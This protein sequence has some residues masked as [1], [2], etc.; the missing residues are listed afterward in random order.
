MA[1]TKKEKIL[2]VNKENV[3]NEMAPLEQWVLWKAEKLKDKDEYAKVPYQTIG[4]RA[5]STKPHS[6]S[7]FEKTIEYID[8]Y[9][10]IGFVLTKDDDYICLDLD[11]IHIDSETYE[12]ITDIAKEVMEKTWWEVSPSGT[13]VHAYFKGTLPEEV[14][15]KNKSEH[16]ELYS[17]SRFMTFTGVNDGVKRE[18]SSNQ[19]Y[20][21]SLVERYFKREVISNDF[22]DREIT[23]SNL[24]DVEVMQLMARSKDADK[25]SKLM[26]GGWQE[27]FESQ[28]EAD[29]SLL[30]ALAFYTQKNAKQMDRIFRNSDL[31]RNK[32]DKLRGNETYGQ[33]SINK[34]INDCINVYDPNYKTSN[35]GF[36]III[37]EKVSVKDLLIKT[38]K[39][40]RERLIKLW[41]DE[42]K[43][44]RKPTS[45]GTN[46]CAYILDD[47]LTFRLFDLEENTKL[48]MYQEEEGIY[49][50]N[51]TII[52]RVISW[53]EP[54][55]N[56]RKA[57]EVIYH[58][59]NTAKVTRQ[60]EQP[61]LIPVNNGVFNRETGI[62][63]PFTPNYVFTSKIS[64]NYV[65][66][67]KQPNIKG[68]DFDKWLSEIACGDSE[69]ITLLWQVINDAMNG[70]YT[71]KKAIFF[72][73]DGNNG[74]GS[75]QQL[76]SNLIGF[77]NIASLKANEF[78]QEFKLSVLEGKTAV[79]GDDVP[80]GIIIEDSSN[81]KSVV[82]GDSVLVNVKN[83]Q[84]YRAEFR[85]TVIQSSNGMPKFKDKTGGNNRRLLIVPFKADFNGLIENVDIKE[86]YL[87]D[88]QVLEYVLYKAINLDFDKFITP[89]ASL[90]MMELYKQ[91]NDPVYDFKLSVFDEWHIRKI[92]K[93][94]VYGFYKDF[95][96]DNGYYPL[97]ERKFHRQ[98][99]GYLDE[100]W[101]IDAQGKYDWEVLCEQIG[102]LNNM[103]TYLDFPEKNKNYKSYE[104]EKMK[105]I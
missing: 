75:F 35:D 78:E 31:I 8:G 59:T 50:R 47:L 92:P 104:N 36:N 72:I 32:W 44:G 23:P 28:S 53:L 81:F 88:T 16:L 80:V 52:K 102:D 84:P 5:D 76:L 39:E 6:W 105:I 12:P 89:K 33:K 79:I 74:K 29:L 18:I 26:S 86:K 94:I 71:R 55:L 1:I 82:T 101:N 19:P 66:N 96:N 54:R 61:H 20:I 46:R 27:L 43:N 45:I 7:D 14:K 100:S 70:N 99:K 87:K 85:C 42:G 58:L 103:R 98:F 67:A 25:I 40:E 4:I 48:A 95:C 69:I 22:I 97:S 10:G 9:E 73:G 63:E 49:T 11:D 13:G 2:K 21:D 3:P 57:E 17:H 77:N 90:D 60:T 56:E 37:N 65:H 41:E 83:K 91:D 68:W 30:N 15:R 93:Y 64:T 51:R 62:L 34:A 24:D 38:G